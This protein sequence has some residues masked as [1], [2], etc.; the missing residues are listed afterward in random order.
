M[1]DPSPFLSYGR[2]DIDENDVAAVV[3]A[4]RSD[5]LTQ[6]PVGPALERALAE[7]LGA[8]DAVVCATGTAA[9]HLTMLAL[10]PA[11][12]DAVVV[13][14]NT[15]LAGANAVRLAGGEV[16]FADIDPETGL[17]TPALMAA[18][19]ERAVA[20]GL[21]PR[22]L[23]PVH[24]AGETVDMAGIAALAADFRGSA[25]AASGGASGGAAAGGLAVVEDACHAIGGE[26]VDSAGRRRPVGSCDHSLAA[27]FSFHPVKTVTAGEGGAI[28]LNDP[29]LAARLRRLR[30]H[31]MI[32]EGFSDPAAAGDPWYYEM[33]E[34]GLNY[35]LTDLQ[36]ALALS[37]L[38]RLDHFVAR[39]AALT[40]V[41]DRLL[42]PLA[43]WVRPL[44][45]AANCRPGRHLYAVLIDFAALGLTRAAVTAGLRGRGIGSQVHYI[46][47]HRQP[48]YRAR[49]G[50]LFLPGADAYYARTLSLPLHPTLRDDDV[51]R[52][53]AALG[54]VLGA[55]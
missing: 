7:R 40:A 11:P 26:T 29:A 21:R 22:A 6:G 14:T 28:T 50:D 23:T 52:V 49:Y 36:A 45:R 13:P 16:V 43:R 48:Y 1:T 10:D 32:R 17:T 2:Q 19:L 33:P 30:N 20:A 24:F 38:R 44:G 35:R 31:G 3:A 47:V 12:G 46:P 53:V 9:L 34:I 4:L 39:R 8:A 5:W 55:G 51:A 18:A 42:A 25:D 54:E 15:F 37:Q 41:Y 27:C